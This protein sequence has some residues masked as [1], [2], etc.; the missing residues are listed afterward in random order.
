MDEFDFKLEKK[1]LF[2][3]FSTEVK[4]QKD[5]YFHSV[6]NLWKSSFFYLEKLQK[7]NSL[8]YLMADIRFFMGLI[9]AV[10]KDEIGQSASLKNHDPRHL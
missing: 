8:D 4:P 10:S 2:F 7:I 9:G 3:G 1:S 5:S 6:E